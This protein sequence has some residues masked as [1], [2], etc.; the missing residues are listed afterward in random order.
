MSLIPESVLKRGFNPLRNCTPPLKIDCRYAHRA[1]GIVPGRWL[2]R[3]FRPSNRL[4][5]A[6]L[7]PYAL[8]C[9]KNYLFSSCCSFSSEK[10]NKNIKDK[11]QELT[12]ESNGDFQPL[13][14]QWLRLSSPNA[15]GR[16]QSLV[17]ELRS[18]S[19][20]KRKTKQNRIS[21]GSG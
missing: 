7:C 3:Q 10:W 16:V 19:S 13:A 21:H 17:E 12:E 20:Q 2:Q 4:L 1:T 5:W 6:W 9:W 15:G 8:W 18:W 14:V 11:I